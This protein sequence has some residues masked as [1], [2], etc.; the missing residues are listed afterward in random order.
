MRPARR[1]RTCKDA[2]MLS[3]WDGEHML[4]TPF[5]VH[6]DSRGTTGLP[7]PAPTKSDAPRP[8]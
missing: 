6:I 5:C 3:F 4:L 1:S 8:L 7:T 2:S